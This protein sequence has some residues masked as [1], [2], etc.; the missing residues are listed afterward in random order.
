MKRIPERLAS[1][2]LTTWTLVLLLLWFVWGI[3][4]VRSEGF[5]KGFELMNS[6]LVREWLMSPESGYP[7]LK[8]WFV[9]LCLVMVLLGIN[10]VFCSWYK[11]VRIIKI[12]FSGAKLF[13]LIVHVIFGLV[14][15]G[16]FGGFML[17]YRQENIRIGEG[18]TVRTRDGYEVKVTGIHFIDDLGVLKKSRRELMRDEFHYRSNF[19]EVMLGREGKEM[20]RE[21]VYM[22]RPLRFKDMQITLK[23]FTLSSSRGEGKKGDGKAGALIAVSK[24][25]VLSIFLTLYPLMIIGILIHLAMTWNPGSGGKERHGFSKAKR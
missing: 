11:I 3:F 18:Q 6:L 4:L 16:H 15:L 8:F 21:R 20:L 12:R 2:H 24:N 5:R 22:L 17:G 25:P 10:L 14:A 9:G 23:R 13:M 1:F 19:I 7:L